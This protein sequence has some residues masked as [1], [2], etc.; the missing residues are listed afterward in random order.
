MTL[1]RCFFVLCTLAALVVYANAETLVVLH[2]NDVHGNVLPYDRN[3]KGGM[4]RIKV[5]ADSIRSAEK[6]VMLL[7]AGDDVQGFLYFSLFGGDVEYPLMEKMGYDVVTLG[8]H[9]FD[10]GLDRLADC[11]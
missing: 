4:L 6:N 1:K 9:E 8:N 7:D 3:D 5:V 2:T 11:Y 10:N